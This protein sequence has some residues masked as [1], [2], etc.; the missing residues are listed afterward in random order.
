MMIREKEKRKC[1]ICDGEIVLYE[2]IG[3]EGAWYTDHYCLE[4]PIG[5][6]TAVPCAMDESFDSHFEDETFGSVK[7]G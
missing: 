1:G 4:C 3:F 2:Y 5:H 6:L 7:G